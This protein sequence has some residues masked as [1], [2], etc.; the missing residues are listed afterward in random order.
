MSQS[1][2]TSDWA[3]TSSPSLPSGRRATTSGSVATDGI[4]IKV[5]PVAQSDVSGMDADQIMTILHG[6]DTDGVLEAAQAHLNLGEKLD[7]VATRLAANAHTLAQNWQGGAAQASMEKFQEMH[8]QTAQL[9]AQAKQTGQVLQWLGQDVL[10]KYKSLP[11]P[12]V[13]SRTASDEQAGAKIGD[14]VAGAPGALVGDVAGGLASAFGFGGNDGQAKANAQAQQYLTALNEH[15]IQANNALPSPIGALPPSLGTGGPS[16]R[17]GTGGGASPA[18]G[19]TGAPVT[20][21]PVHAPVQGKGTAGT[22]PIAHRTGT[23]VAGGTGASTTTGTSAPAPM[24]H[25]GGS[26]AGRTGTLQGLTPTGGGPGPTPGATTTGPPTPSPGGPTPVNNI[27][28]PGG[29]VPSDDGRGPGGTNLSEDD[30]TGTETAPLA[31]TEMSDTA[32]LPG[33]AVAGSDAPLDEAG[34]LGSADPAVTAD[35]ALPATALDAQQ[36]ADA[37]GTSAMG[38]EGAAGTDMTGIPMTGGAGSG[39]QDKERYRQAWMNE[40]EDIWGLPT[41]HVPPVIEGGG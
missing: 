21:A 28:V 1:V 17:T 5:N 26:A 23:G 19:V 31:D 3:G 25:N 6:L 24:P 27:P 16:P 18:P 38:T 40:D 35:E 22:A 11:D 20:G 7:Q 29:P 32:V 39:Q 37:V 14:S 10:P 41:G 33:G 30:G 4:D 13:E 9:A 12:R 15:L 36:T 8:N 34:A 2:L